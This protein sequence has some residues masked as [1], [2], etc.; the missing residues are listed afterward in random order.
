MVWARYCKIFIFICFNFIVR[1]KA[2]GLLEILDNDE[3][4][5]EMRDES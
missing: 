4:I 2:K 3:L 1:E 5:K